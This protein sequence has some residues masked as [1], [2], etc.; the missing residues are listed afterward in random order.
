MWII[1]LLVTAQLVSGNRRDLP[2]IQPL[3]IPSEIV[4]G[5]RFKIG[6]GLSSGTAPVEFKWFKND[7]PLTSESGIQIRTVLEDS[8][9]LIVKQIGPEDAGRYKC[10]VQNEAGS[11]SSQVDVRVKGKF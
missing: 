9:D 6:C 1:V 3:A 8:S 7:E 10:V 4:A 2:V 5:Q 11:D